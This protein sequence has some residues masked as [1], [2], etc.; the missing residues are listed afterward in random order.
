MNGLGEPQAIKVHRLIV[1]GQGAAGLCAAVSAMTSAHA[2]G[3]DLSVTLLD[4]A[5]LA[6][7]GGN[8]RW[9]PS[10]I[11]LQADH[12][13]APGFV[14][15]VVAESGG[16]ADRDYFQQLA[17]QAPAMA[18]WL[19]SLGVVF[20][21]PPYYLAK[22]PA[23][24]QPVGG[25][26]ALLNALLARARDLGIALVDE[27]S[28][29]QL[30]GDDVCVTGV[31]GTDAQGQTQTHHADAV[32]LACGG[33]QGNAAM[34]KQHLGAAA[35]NYRLI[36]QGTAYNDGA[37]IRAALAIGAQAAGDWCTGH[38]EPV[39]PRS[40][41]SAPVVL[42]YPYGV[43]VDAQGQ[44]FFDEGAGLMHETWERFAHQMQFELPGQQAYVILDAKLLN[45]ADY[46]RAIRSDVPPISAPT[47]EALAQALGLPLAALMDTIAAFNAACPDD[48]HSFDPTV[49]DG[50]TSTPVGQVPKS[51]WARPI[52]QSPFL[53][54]PLVGALVYTF[55]GLKTNANAQ[56]LSVKGPI[57]GLYAAGEITGHFYQL[58]PN[59][60]AMLRALVFGK[61]AGEQVVRDLL[62]GHAV[63]H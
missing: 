39:D 2:S 33:F 30:L 27:F 8:S 38:A 25:G 9:S 26:A 21:S 41:N 13:V 57:C 34:R 6:D 55:G 24:I 54:W 19:V 47:L 32:V 48:Q 51:N 56:V 5:P 4:A 46:A 15:E 59:S 10:N 63:R 23:R 40:Q 16:L 62:A 1:V 36:S 42:V 28:L 50:L 45:I 14:D 37:G 7:S 12:H 11:R 58:A 17:D 61:I 49:K 22:G 43:V 44:R 52:D 53:A 3:V 31:V 60:V 20:Q 18:D 29:T 35:E